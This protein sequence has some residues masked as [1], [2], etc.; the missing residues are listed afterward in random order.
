MPFLS[1]VGLPIVLRLLVFLVHFC[2]A[3]LAGVLTPW[4][5]NGCAPALLGVTTVYGNDIAGLVALIAEGYSSAHASASLMRL[6]NLI[7]LT[8]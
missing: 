7:R 1:F 5:L 8:A 3:A 6:Y 2:L 4:T